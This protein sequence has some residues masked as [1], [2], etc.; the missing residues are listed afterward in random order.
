MNTEAVA[1]RLV[2]LCRKGEFEQAQRE[3]FAQDAV[4]IEMPGAPSGA[5]GDAKG[6]EAIYEKGRQFGAMVEAMHSSEVSDPVVAGDW[7]SL[8]MAMDVTFKERGRTQMAELCVYH[9][10]DGKVVSEQFFYDMG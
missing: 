2:E 5:L 3:L 1:K 7:F 8:S 6:L 4:S 9:V 10:R